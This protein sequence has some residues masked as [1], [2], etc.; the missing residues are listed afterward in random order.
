MQNVNEIRFYIESSIFKESLRKSFG[1]FWLI[2]AY[3]GQNSAATAYTYMWKPIKYSS[4]AMEF[5]IQNVVVL[6]QR[7]KYVKSCNSDWKKN[8]E[9]IL[10]KTMEKVEVER[11]RTTQGVERD[12]MT[13]QGTELL[14]SRREE[15]Q[16]A[17]WAILVK[18]R[19]QKA[20]CT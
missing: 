19:H 2:M 6:K 3:P 11:A 9:M 8:D 12:P 16:K 7:K 18:G 10:Q 1:N 20:M 17:F 5:N 15:V 4:F 13:E 14:L